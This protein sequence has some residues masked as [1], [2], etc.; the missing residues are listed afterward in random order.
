MTKEAFQRFSLVVVEIVEV[1]ETLLV[2]DV[3]EDGLGVGKMLVDVVEI[4]HQHFAPAPELVDGFGIISPKHFLHHAVKLA[5]TFEL[6][7]NLN[8]GK[9]L[10]EVAHHAIA[11]SPNWFVAQKGKLTTKE[12]TSTFA[13]EDDCHIAHIVREMRKHI[14]SDYIEKTLHS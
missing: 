7:C 14:G 9:T 8:G 2:G 3:G 4:C 12:H 13:R 5:D 10:E 6:V 1:L 11:G